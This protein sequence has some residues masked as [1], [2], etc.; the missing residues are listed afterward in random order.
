MPTTLV[1]WK[2]VD[3]AEEGG[4]DGGV[5]GGGGGG[6]ADGDVGGGDGGGCRVIAQVLVCRCRWVMAVRMVAGGSGS[7]RGQW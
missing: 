6:G 5:D 7:V 2:E 1:M 3:T 4:V